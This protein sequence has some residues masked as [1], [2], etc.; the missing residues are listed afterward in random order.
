MK[1]LC[2]KG[3]KIGLR[4]DPLIYYEDWK[5]GYKNLIDLIFENINVDYIHSIS[6]GSLRFPIHIYK[7]IRLF[8]PGNKLLSQNLFKNK[9]V[10]SINKEIEDEMTTYCINLIKSKTETNLNYFTCS[11]Y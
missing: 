2:V 1:K 8:Y 10:Y 4:F 11:S 5:I 9:K 7:K 3:W 6:F